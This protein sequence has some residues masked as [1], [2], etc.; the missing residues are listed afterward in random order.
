MQWT[1][2]SFT[3]STQTDKKKWTLAD[4]S[5]VLPLEKYF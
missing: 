1:T 5:P 4:L 2:H 3:F